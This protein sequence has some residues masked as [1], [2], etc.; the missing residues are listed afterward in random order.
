LRF[1][2]WANRVTPKRSIGKYPFE[3]V[4]GKSTIFP[5]KL[6]MSVAKILQDVEEEPISQNQRINQLVELQESNH[7]LINDQQ[8]MKSLFHKNE[9]DKPL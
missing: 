6:A 8:K 4:Y 9:R 1:A 5:I 3:L 7:K 2:L